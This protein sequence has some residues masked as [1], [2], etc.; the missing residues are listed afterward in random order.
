MI[1]LMLS[2]VLSSAD[3]SAAEQAFGIGR[4]EQAA[5]LY[6]RALTREDLDRAAL[7]FN[8]GLCALQQELPARALLFTRSGLLHAPRHPRLRDLERRLTKQLNLA[9]DSSVLDWPKQVSGFQL[10]LLVTLLQSLFLVAVLLLRRRPLLRI[11]MA[12]LAVVA[13]AAGGLVL[14]QRARPASPGGIVLDGGVSLRPEP[15][16]S[17]PVGRR[18]PPGSSVQILERTDRWIRVRSDGGSGWTGSAGIGI[19]ESPPD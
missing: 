13:L 10:L 2:L 16:A 7:L 14:M 3:L 4:F 1:A 15:H 6:Q 18:L 8:L 11:A 12:L 5:D 19:M 9:T 17:V